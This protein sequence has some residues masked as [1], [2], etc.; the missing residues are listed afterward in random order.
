MVT[1]GKWFLSLTNI[2]F[3]FSGLIIIGHGDISSVQF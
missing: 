2:E 3:R 1:S